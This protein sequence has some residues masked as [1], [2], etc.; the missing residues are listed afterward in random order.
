M[1][2]GAAVAPEKIALS[3]ARPADFERVLEGE[4]RG[5]ACGSDERHARGGRER[6]GECRILQGSASTTSAAATSMGNWRSPSAK[7]SSRRCSSWQWA[8]G[9][10]AAEEQCGFAVRRA[11]W[12]TLNIMAHD[13]PFD[14]PEDFYKKAAQTTLKDYITIGND[15]REK[16]YFL[17]MYLSCV[18]AADYL[19]ERPDWD[20]R[21][22]VVT[23]T[24][25]G[26][27]Q[28]LIT[29]GL[30]PKITA[31]MANVRGGVRR[32]RAVDRACR[33]VP[34]LGEQCQVEE[35]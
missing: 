8:G 14:Q 9:V 20:G 17:R 25:Q 1:L 26:G 2:V 23:G 12:L 27:Q 32:D 28:T 19:A 22:M 29:A 33:G 35:E 5:A 24:S 34:V 3:A 16:S 11:G 13:L 10:W 15:D 18:R 21:V 4:D 30:H 6:Q 7:A 31:L